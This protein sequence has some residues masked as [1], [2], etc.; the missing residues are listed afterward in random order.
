M[1][2]ANNPKGGKATTIIGG[3][4][5]RGSDLPQLRGKYIFGIFSQPGGTPNAELYMSSPAGSGLWPFEE[6]V[7]KDRPN[8]IGWTRLNTMKQKP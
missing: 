4:I 7:L 6:L 8:D 5:Y 3:N 1:N 2:N